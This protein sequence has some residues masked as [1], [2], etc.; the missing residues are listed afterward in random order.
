MT[1]PAI[2][3]AEK[4]GH[5]FYR[6]NEPPVMSCADCGGDIY[7]NDGYY[8]C[9]ICKDCAGLYTWTHD[10]EPGEDP[11]ACGCCGERIEAQRQYVSLPEG[12]GDRCMDCFEKTEITA[13]AA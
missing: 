9:G 11:L 2:L 12:D 10:P 1:D 7:E 4:W 3:F 8:E 13:V 5:D 6:L